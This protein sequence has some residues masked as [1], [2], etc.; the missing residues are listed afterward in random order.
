MGCLDHRGAETLDH[1]LVALPAVR[2]GDQMV[3]VMDVD[4][5]VLDGSAEFTVAT[6]GAGVVLERENLFALHLDTA[7]GELVAL[8]VVFVH[9]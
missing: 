1:D 6:D 4:G 3:A 7:D 8:R 9:R 2:E 5:R